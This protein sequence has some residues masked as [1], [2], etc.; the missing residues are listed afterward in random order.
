E[1]AHQIAGEGIVV[2]DADVQGFGQAAMEERCLE[3]DEGMTTPVGRCDHAK[4]GHE[5]DEG[6][7][8]LRLEIHAR[9]LPGPV[10]FTRMH[11]VWSWRRSYNMITRRRG[12]SDH[13][14]RR[15]SL[16]ATIRPRRR[17]DPTQGRRR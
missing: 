17:P 8:R 12:S 11:E 1:V 2:G 16:G 3:E 13:A 5:G 14:G 15:F 7:V 4:E 9:V 6:L 10:D